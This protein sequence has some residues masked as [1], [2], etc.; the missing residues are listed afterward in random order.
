MNLRFAKT[1]HNIRNSNMKKLV[2]L[3]L[4]TLA[5]NPQANAMVPGGLKIFEEKGSVHFH[6]ITSPR[7]FKVVGEASG[8]QGQLVLDQNQLK[9]SLA[10]DLKKLTTGISLRDSHMKEKYLEVDKYPE[11]KLIITE[12]EVPA[13]LLSNLNVSERPFKANLIVRGQE[14]PVK[15][16]FFSMKDGVVDAR[17]QIL[18]SEYDINNPSHLGLTVGNSVEVKVKFPLIKE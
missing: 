5:I 9:G 16:G 15:E 17:F 6:A 10:F 1:A 4:I 14:K 18:L 13:E 3:V 11:A 7:L 8:P 2:F 12:A